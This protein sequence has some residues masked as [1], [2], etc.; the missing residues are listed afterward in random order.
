MA[1]PVVPPAATAAAIPQQQQAT[2]GNQGGVNALPATEFSGIRQV[3]HWLGYT[4][5]NPAM[6]EAELKL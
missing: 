1:L 6:L 4:M 5:L 3:L 2:M